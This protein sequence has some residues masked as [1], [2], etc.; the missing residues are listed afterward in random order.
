[1]GGKPV[2]G[3]F[4]KLAHAFL[5]ALSHEL[6]TP[7]TSLLGYAVT[8]KRIEETSAHI[9]PTEKAGMLDAMVRKATELDALI[10]DL[11]DLDRMSI[12]VTQAIRKPVELRGLILRVAERLES[13]RD[14]IRVDSMSCVIPLDPSKI[15]RILEVFLKNAFR[16]A[17]E[18]SHVAVSTRLQDGGVTICVE[19]EGPGIPEE[20]RLDLFEPF[21]QAPGAWSHSPGVGIGLSLAQKFAELHGGRVWAE[22]RA[23]GGTAFFVFLPSE[24]AQHSAA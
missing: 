19:D 1:M 2:E 5:G 6:R 12:G 15:E 9:S 13:S 20:L 23:Q 8:L 14:R 16:Y 4:D 3:G 11:L 17:P 21:R 18:G 7:L 10:G 22:E 24:G